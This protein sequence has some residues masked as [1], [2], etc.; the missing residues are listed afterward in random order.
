MIVVGILVY[1]EQRSLPRLL[2]ELSLAQQELRHRTDICYL[3][4]NDGSSDASRQL[5][6]SG[7]S[8]TTVNHDRNLGIGHAIQSV[9][10]F[11]RNIQA[12]H[13]LLFPGNGRVHPSVIAD[14]ISTADRNPLAYI[15]SNRFL[16]R[17][18]AERSFHHFA[19]RAFNFLLRALRASKL[20]DVTSCTRIFPTSVVD[21]FHFRGGYYVEQDL[22][23]FVH[24][25]NR[26]ILEIPVVISQPDDRPKSHFGLIGMLQV[27]R[28]WVSPIR[29]PIS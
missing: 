11:A 25:Q 20:G 26:P 14:L 24:R 6:E 4:V 5:I 7:F 16:G 18:A 12:S 17:R 23:S 27:L 29:S 8:G 13:V 10:V 1:N 21:D 3:L 22:H 28:A 15:A 2:R 9:I 19:I